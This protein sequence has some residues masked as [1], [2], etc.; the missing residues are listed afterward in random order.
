MIVQINKL[1]YDVN[2]NEFKQ[3]E[4]KE[5]FN[6]LI[7]DKLGFFERVISLLSEISE[8]D[9]HNVLVCNPTHGAFIPINLSKY[10]KNIFLTNIKQEQNKNIIN[11]ITRFNINNIFFD[12]N[13]FGNK[14]I[15]YSE[16][17]QDIDYEIIQK[18][19]QIILTET[20]IK[21]IKKYKY[22]YE[23]SNTNFLFYVPEEYNDLFKEQFKYYLKD[24]L[25]DFNNLINLCIMVKNGGELFQQML[26]KN[27]DIFDRWTILDTGSTDGTQDVIKNLLVGKKNGALYEE[28]FINFRESRNRCL[29]LA[30][31]KCKYNLMLDD[32]YVIEGDLRSFLTEI[33]G[34]QFGDSYSLTVKS[35]DVE[36]ISN[37][38][39]KSELKLKYIYTMHEVI[40]NENNINVRV[41]ENR[42]VINDLNNAYMQN[43]SDTRKEYDLKCLY[44]MLEEYPNEPR[45][46]F[47]LAQ[48]YKMLNNFEKAAEYY[49]KR[50]FFHI[51]GFEQE[52]FDA[53]FEFTRISI[54]KLKK[55]WREYEK[56]YKLCIEW[57]PTR[58]EGDYFLGINYF[59]DND[60]FTAFKHFKKAFEIGF[61]YHQQYSLKPTLSFHFLPYYLS[62][63]CYEFRDFKLGLESTTLFLQKNKPTDD[64]YNLIADWYKIYEMLNKLPSIKNTPQTF[65]KPIFC[66]VADGGFTK[67]SGK[68]ILTSG[69]GGSE[70]WVIE[71][72]RYINQLSN[73]EVIVFCNCEQE[74]IFE[75]VK[76]IQLSRYL[77]VIS[78]IKIEHCI[79]S[80]FSEYIPATIEGHV[81][82][83]Y[84]ILHDLQLSGNV[85]PVH[86]KIKNIF[87]LTEWH[88]RHFLESFSQFEKITYSLHYGI[89]FN[90]FLNNEKER[91]Y[92]QKIPYSFIYSSFPNRGL[93]VVLKMWPR[94]IKRYPQS[95]L[96]IFTDVNNKWANDFYPDELK[97]IRETL[98]SYKKLYPTSV[99]NHGW[100]DKKTL[101]DFWKQ[102]SIWLYPCKFKETFCLTALESAVTKTLAITNDLAALQD[103]V[104]DRGIII[105]GDATTEEWQQTAFEKICEVLD[106][107][108]LSESFIERNYHWA[109]KHSWKDRAN[110]LLQTFILKKGNIS[111][112]ENIQMTLTEIVDKPLK[113]IDKIY[114]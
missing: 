19:N 34:D 111:E 15:I 113:S 40:Q 82:N 41:P 2:E 93:S 44:E 79:I 49:Y 37:R 75:G 12:S 89:D 81:E 95:V 98:D 104:G 4:H 87:C 71:T 65:D 90:N 69:V 16:N 100:V 1:D 20:N 78:E 66:I 9:F 46:L 47:Y 99:L 105:P 91:N 10:F 74:E 102:S 38:I 84:L 88:K 109:L 14:F 52:K 51:E 36:Y 92:I 60:H 55:P 11:N 21:L 53:L 39:T 24:D 108:S 61:P 101:A 110:Y 35:H 77:Q 57:Q 56:Y 3:V 18:Y 33:R 28:P 72:A 5:Y 86:N 112:K 64:F 67:W 80:R 106:N 59:I 17:Y 23:I 58:P 42:A 27:I 45:H 31:T 43:R 54:Y 22:T 70:T 103:T 96:N 29:E 26:V 30:G 114:L 68:N 48:T 97:E 62:S 73:F 107:F 6:L 63:L 76:Y 83:I 13:N 32:T 50:A 85:I 7:R 8:I 25:L 94:I